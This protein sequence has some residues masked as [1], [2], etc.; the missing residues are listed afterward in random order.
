MQ[1]WLIQLKEEEGFQFEH[2]GS[3]GECNKC[4][5][6]NRVSGMDGAGRSGL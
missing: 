6:I 2:K 1:L 3:D 4:G 5:M